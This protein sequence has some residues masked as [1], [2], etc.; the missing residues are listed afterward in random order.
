MPRHLEV[1]VH[2]TAFRAVARGLKS[3][4]AKNFDPAQWEE[5]FAQA[6][7]PSPADRKLLE[8]ALWIGR[9]VAALNE[10][11]G[12]LF[13][14]LCAEQAI[15][16]GIALVNREFW[17]SADSTQREIAN[18]PLEKPA[19]F[20]HMANLRY[21]NIYGQKMSAADFVENGIEALSSWIF[22]A[23]RISPSGKP[24]CEENLGELAR[25]AI[26]HYSMRRVLKGL[27]D[28]A[29]HLGTTLDEDGNCWRPQDRKLDELRKA[30][31]AR[32]ES[33]LMDEPQLLAMQ[34]PHLLPAQRR[35]LALPRS[36]S[37]VRWSANGW[38]GKVRRIE[39]L[40]KRPRGYALE[41]R[42]LESSYLGLFLDE[43]LP[44][45]PG[46]TASILHQAWWVISDLANLIEKSA[47]KASERGEL[48]LLQAAY[49]TTER[50]LIRIIADALK[51]PDGRAREIVAFL[52]FREGS[53]GKGNR[54]LWSEPLVSSGQGSLLIPQAIFNIG[55]PIYRVEAWLER[56]G[57]DDSAL[58]RRGDRFEAKCRAG[59]V[60]ALGE[61][62]TLT[63]AHIAPYGIAKNK[64]FKHQTDLLFQIGNRAFVGEIKCWLT[65]AD[66][67]HWD[68]FYRLRLP[69]AVEQ[70]IVRA[71]A[72]RMN[73][74]VLASALGISQ[75]QADGLEI[76]PIVVLNLPAGFSLSSRGCRIIDADFLRSYLR[77]P[78]MT[79][80]VAMHYGKPVMQQVVSLYTSEQDAA[81][82]FDRI[83]AAPWSLRRFCDR[84]ER[85][86]I[87]Y[88]R[89]TG[90][91]FKIETLFR[92][93]LTPEEKIQQARLMELV[94]GR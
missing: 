20:D 58:D 74:A 34:W 60:A 64:S 19:S 6:V 36:V 3:P 39:Y 51:I 43:D 40:S 88:P 78:Q 61:N 31:Q 70:A 47:R 54:G 7:E 27:F 73:R 22:D 13:G 11:S 16:L 59:L 41:R 1:P 75:T 76:S 15:A 14:T 56:G 12:S 84:L 4:T 66:P 24:G 93:D 86:D 28:G 21:E 38:V 18:L 32:A 33:N 87:S 57:M 69:E 25:E 91:T 46:L 92:G 44:L 9:E 77:S 80:G 26:H 89:P 5:A 67:H 30:W 79:S 50:A 35:A 37:E 29:L 48:S 94:T 90:G 68:R 49:A 53:S 52:T 55:D 2:E 17:T 45:A 71:N 83:M 81:D 72:L 85:S 42:A 23:R 65:P 10:R 8:S 62:K 63:N 82:S